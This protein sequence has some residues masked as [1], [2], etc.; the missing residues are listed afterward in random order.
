V[1]DALLSAFKHLARFEGRSQMSSWI[2]AIVINSVR[3]QLRRDGTR[4]T[5]DSNPG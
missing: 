4:V 2:M 1:Q 5:L 3:V